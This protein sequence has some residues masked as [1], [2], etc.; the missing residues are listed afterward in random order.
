M[1]RGF[2]NHPK[3]PSDRSI[4]MNKKSLENWFSLSGVIAMVFYGMHVYLGQLNYP[5]YQWK[6]QAISDLTAIDAASYLI[7]S[8]FSSLYGLFACIC[9]LMLCLL[10]RGKFNKASRLGFY[11]YSIMIFVS[12]VGYTLFPLSGKGYQGQFQDIMHVFVVTI[13]VVLLSIVSLIFIAIG[14]FRR[15]G[16]RVVGL[17]AVVALLLMFFGS[18]GMNVFPKE[19]FGILER[20]SVLSVVVYTGIL[21]IFGFKI[22]DNR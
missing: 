6:S 16:N 9:C 4:S 7:A 11:L 8:R 2:I 3:G 13:A 5:G 10:V 17:L 20:F 21:G 12:T 1:R 22:R 19:Y 18:I 15:N 14:G